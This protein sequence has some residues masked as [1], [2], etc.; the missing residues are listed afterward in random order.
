VLW[1]RGF[2]DQANDQAQ[3]SLEEAQ[4]TA[5]ELTLCWVLHYAV[6]PVALMTGDLVAAERAVAMLIDSAT[7]LN[8]A[9][10]K[11][12]GRCLQGKLLIGRREFSAGSALL[13]TALETCDRTGWTICYPEFMGVL[14]EGLAG[15][16]Q[17]SEALATVDQ[18]LAMADRGGERWYIAELLRI[19]GELLLQSAG[20]QSISMAEDCFH[21]ALGV[22]EQQGALFWELRSALSLARLRMIQDRQDDARQTLLP[23]YERFTEGFETADLRA[24][25][26][27]LEAL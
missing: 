15:L 2:L 19:K 16:G 11:I 14:A 12:V 22:A 21:G 10:W 5:Y 26:E 8:A 1:L 23:V 18:A 3:A 9:F 7:S 25:R 13:R 6:C 17:L 20:D 27:M 24:A 4:V